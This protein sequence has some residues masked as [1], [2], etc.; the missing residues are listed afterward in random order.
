MKILRGIQVA[1]LVL[2]E[3]SARGAHLASPSLRQRIVDAFGEELTAEQAVQ[4]IIDE[5]RVDGDD[6]LF[7]YT[8]M[9]DGSEVTGLEVTPGEIADARGQVS[10]ELVEALN[11]AAQRIRSFHLATKRQDW[12]D[13]SEGGVGQVVRPLE[14]VGIYIP[15]GSAAYPSTVL[16]T[17]IPA[18]VAGVKE[19]ILVAPPQRDGR[20]HPATVV[21][22][23][24][25]KADRLFKVGGAQ[26]IAALAF[27]TRSIPKVDKICG[28]GNIF[29]Q[30][31]KN[32]VHSTVDIDGVYG[33]T[34]TVII[35]DD[36]M[37]P[38]VCAA[39]LLAQAE[40]DPLASAILITT[41]GQLAASVNQEVERQLAIL[42]RKD[43]ARASLDERGAIAVVKSLEEAIELANDYAPEHLSLVVR[44]AWSYLEKI[45]N[46]GGVFI[47]ESSPEVLGDYTAG[48]SHVMPTGGAARFTSPL[49][50]DDF[51]KVI[52][53]VALNREA[54]KKLGPAAAVIAR[55]EGLG[56]HARAVEVR[57]KSGE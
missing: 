37:N 38:V 57:L 7:K 46:A 47:G 53:I 12:I 20:M 4:R 22:A 42:E 8:R 32:L 21:A 17:A 33:P 16:M 27:G 24:I 40:H 54:L 49:T 25:A 44:N 41:S 30:L 18:R 13:F 36:T 26:A 43:I 14:R 31:A 39:D 3:R 1:R 34:E 45:K 9:L 6:A 2:L 56:G 55:A 5:V 23:D 51:L 50:V 11:L 10:Q 35:A 29:V 48:P 19:V 52:S 15:G 28:P